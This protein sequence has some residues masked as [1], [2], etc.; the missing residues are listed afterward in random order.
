M[1]P[2]SG[3][4]DGLSVSEA[5]PDRSLF[6]LVAMMS[7]LAALTLA[8]ATGAR[9]LSARWAGG[10]AQ[11]VT[12]QVPDPDQ[13]LKPTS[14]KKDPTG[15]SRA[16]TVLADLNTLPPGTVVH[17]LDKEELARLL[18]PW[19]GE[20]DNSALPLPAII[21]IRLPD[22]TQVPNDL[23]QTLTAH[24]PGTIVEHNASWGERLKA[25]ANSLL[26]CAGLALLTV[27]G[28]ATLVT[29]LAT[30]AG[31]STRR[32]I[33]EILHGLGASDGYIAG[34]FAWR[35][36][37]LGLGGSLAGTVLAMVPLLVLFR[38]AAPFAN[39]SFQ[40]DTLLLPDWKTLQNVIPTD[41]L[42]AFAALPFAAA[43]IC[44]ITTQSMVRLWLRRLP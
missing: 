29:G 30:R 7:F 41:M 43:F 18:E 17:R 28:I 40:S 11:L 6:T 21:R 32:D 25:L 14:N 38:M 8:G 36:A 23:E 12:V 35:T 19:L 9:A 26:A 15:P 4:K 44:W 27:G 39:I 34:R 20:A 31:L 42:V 10:A 22:R 16:E 1:M 3:R 5:L 13:P 37:M 33:I 2:F 24:V